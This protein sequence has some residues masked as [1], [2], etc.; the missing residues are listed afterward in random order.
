[1]S[2]QARKVILVSILIIFLVVIL[3]FIQ[4]MWFA[5]YSED[6]PPPLSLTRAYIETQNHIVETQISQTQTATA[7]A[8][9]VSQ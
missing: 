6:Q 3:L 2:P 4:L 5:G 8:I 7:K 1:V 9:G